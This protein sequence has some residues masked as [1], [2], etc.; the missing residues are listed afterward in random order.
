MKNKN[1]L[2]ANY[3]FIILMIGSTRFVHCY[4]HHQ[5][6]TTIVLIT[7]WAVR[8]CCWLEVTYNQQQPKNGTAHVVISTIVVSS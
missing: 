2:D 5:E 4:A 8:C 1:Q 6:L 7:T 3:C